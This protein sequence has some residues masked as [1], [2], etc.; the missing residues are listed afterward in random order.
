MTY[1]GASD[2]LSTKSPD[3][4]TVTTTYDGLGHAI[5]Q[6]DPDSGTSTATYDPNGN[7]TQ[8]VDARAS[9]GTINA[10]YDGLNRQLWR[11]GTN[12]PTNAWVTYSYDSTAN[13]DHG[14]G[15]LTSENFTGS[16]SLSGSYAYTYDARGQ[17]TQ[18][19][20]DDQWD[21]VYHQGTYNDAGQL[22]YPD[23]SHG[24]NGHAGLLLFSGWL[25][26]LATFS[27]GETTTLA[28][29]LTYSGLAGAA[30][31]DQF[32]ESGQWHLRL[33]CQLRYRDRPDL[34]RT[35]QYQQWHPTLSDATNL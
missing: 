14:V 24:R 1:N 11:N 10:G 29:N 23:L 19:V 2:L 17:Q 33:R 21:R 34:G 35:H 32:H 25:T 15:Q 26:G 9:A 6:S 18:N 16:G 5:S 8:T 4:S 27:G 3:G 31:Q 28:S 22:L 13:G 20:E 30:G 12:S 7:V